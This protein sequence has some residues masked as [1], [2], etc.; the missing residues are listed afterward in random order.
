MIN[1][2]QCNDLCFF[3]GFQCVEIDVWITL[4]VCYKSDPSEGSRTQ[5]FTLEK[6]RIFF[7]FEENISYYI[8]CP[9]ILRIESQPRGAIHLGPPHY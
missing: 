6:I 8:F 7:Q 3:Q 2:F 5:S 4:L 1:L 9:K